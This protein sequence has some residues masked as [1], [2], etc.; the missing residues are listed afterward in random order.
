M[1]NKRPMATE[2]LRQQVARGNIHFSEELQDKARM[3]KVSARHTS[4]SNTVNQT[5]VKDHPKQ[6]A[7]QPGVSYPEGY[8]IISRIDLDAGY[9]QRS[10]ILY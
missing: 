5:D 6:E 4:L 3:K 9:P 8:S 2:W 1:L 7:T 10:I